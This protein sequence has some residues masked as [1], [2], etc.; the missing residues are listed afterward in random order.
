MGTIS[1]FRKQI[2]KGVK[3]GQLRKTAG[4]LEHGRFVEWAEGSS[5]A[6]SRF[7]TALQPRSMHLSSIGRSRPTLHAALSG[8]LNRSKLGNVQV[9]ALLAPW[10][11]RSPSK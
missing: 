9:L 2:R 5:A 11:R 1:E 6:A 4:T 7:T 8:H 10:L 3:G